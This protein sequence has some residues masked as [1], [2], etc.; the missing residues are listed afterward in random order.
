MFAGSI[1]SVLRYGNGD[2]SVQI[3]LMAA[4]KGNGMVTTMRMTG[5]LT[6]DGDDGV[7]R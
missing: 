7:L 5:A 2:D 3:Y 4:L 1:D 6:N